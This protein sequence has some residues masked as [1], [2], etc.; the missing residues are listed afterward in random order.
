MT[1]EHLDYLF[2]WLQLAS[3]CVVRP[4]L[5]EAFGGTFVAVTPELG[6][7]FLD[8]PRSAR[9]QIELVQRPKQD[10]LSAT[11]VVIFFQP[12]PLAALQRRCARLGQASV[13]LLSDCVHRL[14]KIFGDVELS[15]TMSACGIH[16]L[17]ALIYAGHISV[18]CGLGKAEPTAQLLV[19]ARKRQISFFFPNWNRLFPENSFFRTAG[20]TR[21]RNIGHSPRPPPVAVGLTVP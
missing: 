1:P 20:G 19:V 3:H 9:F 14:V 7:V 17:V 10:G 4:G 6:E 12:R 5:E 16:C 15:C 18:S 11:A 13:F 21:N 2:D 8:A